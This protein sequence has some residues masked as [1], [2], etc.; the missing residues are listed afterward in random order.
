MNGARSEKFINFQS[1]SRLYLFGTRS[2]FAPCIGHR[3]AASD[4]V[5]NSHK[6]A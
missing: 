5:T 1:A 2:T 4:W 3:T 6:S